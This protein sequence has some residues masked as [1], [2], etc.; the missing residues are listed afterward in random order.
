MNNWI[1]INGQEPD[2]MKD[3]K[4]LWFWICNN[5]GQIALLNCTQDVYWQ[6][7]K[8]WMPVKTPELPD[9]NFLKF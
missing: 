7:I 2:E 6:Y 4:P 8:F 5:Y 9:S 3:S 1:E